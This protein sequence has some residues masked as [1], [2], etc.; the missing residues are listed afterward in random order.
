M[1]SWG[2]KRQ[3]LKG[4]VVTTS[5]LISLVQK[6]CPKQASSPSCRSQ[7]RCS[8]CPCLP[9]LYRAEEED[10]GAQLRFGAGLEMLTFIICV[11]VP[12]TIGSTTLISMF[13]PTH[14]TLL[15]ALERRYREV[16]SKATWPARDRLW[17]GLSSFI[18]SPSL[19]QG[20]RT[21]LE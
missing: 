16:M 19:S 20:S 1:G 7:Q 2:G 12:N 6:P 9:P 18:W 3:G 4:P 21:F 17:L 13:N 15:V 5:G 8:P 11:L 10:P 14:W